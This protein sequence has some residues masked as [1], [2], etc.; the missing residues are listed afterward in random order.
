MVD[1][2]PLDYRPR[3][4]DI[5]LTQITGAGGAVIR[6]AQWAAGDG[7]R[8]FEHAFEVTDWPDP[9][10]YRIVEAM[11]GGAVH[12]EMWHDP[13]RTLW[14]ICPD[15][16]RDAVEA[17]ALGMV[18]TP[19]SFVDYAAIAAHRFHLPVPHL[20]KFVADS[21]HLICSQLVDRAALRGGW[22]IFDDGRDPGDVTPGD[23]VKAAIKSGGRAGERY[24]VS[25]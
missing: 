2:G 20:K 1:L 6:A 15:Q 5:G 18:G 14:L 3:P 21:G 11:P 22:H 8:N 16:Y 10:T 23:L 25:R 13:D 12:V 9:D 4:G 17:E 19:Y 24:K 7:F